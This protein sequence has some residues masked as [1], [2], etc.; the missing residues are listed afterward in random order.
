MTCTQLSP[1]DGLRRFAVAGQ[2]L[3][4]TDDPAATV[5]AAGAV[6]SNF[7]LALALI[8]HCDGLLVD[9]RPA[10]GFSV[11]DV[12]STL[13]VP[14]LD[15]MIYV[16]HLVRPYVGPPP[17]Q[18]LNKECPICKIPF[19]AD[20]RV[21]MCRC[22]QFYHFETAQS[23]PQVSDENRLNCFQQARVCHC[24]ASLT[25]EEQWTWSADDL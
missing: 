18:L 9:G 13:V 19:A 17:Q 14:G 6:A 2:A 15:G 11:L 20:T 3:V 25:A 5:F 10:L 12:K 21:G 1:A 24:G 16:A 4:T 8:R 7:H 23:H 22:G